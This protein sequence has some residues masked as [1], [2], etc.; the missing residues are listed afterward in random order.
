MVKKSSKPTKSTSKKTTSHSSPTLTLQQAIQ[1]ANQHYNANQLA[2]AEALC[3]NILQMDPQNS[4]ALYL[5][6]LIADK[7][8]QT[9]VAI[10][11]IKQAILVNPTVV[12]FHGNL[13]NL[14]KKQGKLTEATQCYQQV[15]NLEPQSIEAYNNLGNV[16][17]AQGQL[18]QAITYF[19]TAIALKPDWPTAHVGYSLALLKQG[20]FTL[21]WQEYEWRLK[22]NEINTP[23]L[24]QPRWDG[25]PLTGQILLI[26]WEQGFGDTI[27]F[28]RYLTLLTGSKLIFV[29]PAT[30]ASLLA[31]LSLVATIIAHD[32]LDKEPDVTYDIW[33]PLLSLPYHFATTLNNIPATV[34]YLHPDPI[35]IKQWQQRLTQNC[36]KIGI[37]WSG[38]PKYYHDQNRSCSLTHFVKLAKLPHV[39]LL[40]LQT[41]T[42]AN[43]PI[44]SEMNLVSLTTDLKDFSDTAAIIANLDL[45]ISVDTAVAH[46]AGAIGRP[47]WVLLPFNSDWR[48][49][50]T[51][52]DTPWYPTMRLF[53]QPVPGDWNSV[54]DQVL[55][56]LT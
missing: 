45:V 3:R 49:L 40:S 23:Q 56:E 32:R 4:V 19:Q 33:V 51:R 11:L 30:L 10:N 31:N 8:G 39:T 20:K 53:R 43:Q 2:A 26:H 18:E 48:W 28:S 36:F 50:L 55:A 29:V 5:L 41:G 44:P 15:L 16:L 25:T 38:N 14:L 24:K 54:F 46:L 52:Q 21:G 13:G 6:G 37:V 35:K 22:N 27:Q 17:K 9:E 1:M 12:A 34:P 42:A 7:M 47:V